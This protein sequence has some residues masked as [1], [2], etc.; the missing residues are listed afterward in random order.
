MYNFDVQKELVWVRYCIGV[1]IIV[2]CT[3]LAHRKIRFGPEVLTLKGVN[4][5]VIRVDMW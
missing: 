3:F 2:K 5:V 1:N 4:I